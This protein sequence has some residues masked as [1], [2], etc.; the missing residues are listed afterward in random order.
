ML[1]AAKHLV[2]QSLPVL[3]G[4]R[5]FAVLTM[6]TPTSLCHSTFLKLNN[7]SSGVQSTPYLRIALEAGTRDQNQG[8]S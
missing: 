1:S 3:S 4:T 2:R 6:T 5:S 7:K 8:I